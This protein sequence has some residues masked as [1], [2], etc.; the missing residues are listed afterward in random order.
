MNKILF[1]REVDIA[2]SIFFFALLAICADLFFNGGTGKA[3]FAYKEFVLKLIF[4]F[5]LSYGFYQGYKYFKSPKSISIDLTEK[6]IDL[7]D[8]RTVYLNSNDILYIEERSSNYHALFFG[9]IRTIPVYTSND[10]DC[11]L[12]NSVPWIRYT[13]K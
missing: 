13:K 5:V 10:I 6:R 3:E 4:P 2:N 11:L 8:G 9:E 12:S 1:H 7:S